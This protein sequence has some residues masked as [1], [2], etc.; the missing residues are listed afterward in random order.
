MTG[1]EFALPL[2]MGGLSGG[3][4][5]YMQQQRD[6]KE[7]KWNQEDYAQQRADALADFERTNQYNSPQQQ[8]V[9]LRQAGLNPNLVYGKGADNTSAMVRSSNINKSTPS[10]YQIPEQPITQIAQGFMDMQM[11]QAQTDNLTI[12]ADL[13]RKEAL[14]KDVTATKV[15]QET[16]N[17]QFQLQQANSLK[18]LVVEQAKANLQNT[19]ATTV[20]TQATTLLT[21]EKTKEVTQNMSLAVREDERRQLSSLDNHNVAIQDIA[22][23]KLR[24][25]KNPDEVALLKATVENAKN[26]GMVKQAQS[27]LAKEGVFPNDPWYF[28]QMTI[29]M[30]KLRNE[31][32]QANTTPSGIYLPPLPVREN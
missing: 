17:S 30:Q 6:K 11:K 26:E 5:A 9:R 25:A 16:A 13:M 4:N 27:I 10:A 21:N 28:K 8:M 2:I 31:Q 7:R 18:D 12:Q 1:L 20:G 24:I 32:K 3:V 14:L 15:L 23:R 19:Q 29:I 22:E